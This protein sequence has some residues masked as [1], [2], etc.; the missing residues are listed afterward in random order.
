MKSAEVFYFRLDN[1]SLNWVQSRETGEHGDYAN[2]TEEVNTTWQK[3]VG[4]FLEV[5]APVCQSSSGQNTPWGSRLEVV[6][7]AEIT[8]ETA[9]EKVDHSKLT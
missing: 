7:D 9:E 5:K 4:L 6:N 8:K 2:E 1:S 3:T